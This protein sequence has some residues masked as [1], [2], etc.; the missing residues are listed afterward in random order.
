MSDMKGN[1]RYQ[2]YI[3][4]SVLQAHIAAIDE[5]IHE[6]ETN[7]NMDLFTTSDYRMNDEKYFEKYLSFIEGTD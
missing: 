2:L 3:K 5:T 1:F 6:I 7:T 4:R